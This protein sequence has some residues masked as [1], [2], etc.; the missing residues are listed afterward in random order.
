MCVCLVSGCTQGMSNLRT[1][2]YAS[3]D[4]CVSVT[5]NVINNECVNV[6]SVVFN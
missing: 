3:V 5:S 1:T 6:K 2:D 4:A